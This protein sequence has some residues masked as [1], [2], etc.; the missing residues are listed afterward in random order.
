MKKL[1]LQLRSKEQAEQIIEKSLL[2][3]LQTID[4]S[5]KDS[6]RRYIKIILSKDNS[7]II[8]MLDPYDGQHGFILYAYFLS[9]NETIFP[10][11]SSVVSW[12]TIESVSNS[13]ATITVDFAHKLEVKNIDIEYCLDETDFIKFSTI[14]FTVYDN[15]TIANH[16]LQS[17]NRYNDCMALKIYCHINIRCPEEV[18]FEYV[19]KIQYSDIF[20]DDRYSVLTKDTS[21]DVEEYYSLN[22]KEAREII[23][24]TLIIGRKLI[25]VVKPN[26][27]EEG[28][29][30]LLQ[31]TEENYNV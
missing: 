30:I 2:E 7:I 29:I 9:K 10:V 22:A 31:L 24:N 28:K 4:T 20:S 27:H 18:S 16:I 21:G 13:L 25:N 14:D 11:F 5:Q 12:S 23:M 6:G 3:L 8:K 19:M 17:M 1:T 15:D 26:T